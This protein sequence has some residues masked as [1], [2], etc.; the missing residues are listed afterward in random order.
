MRL[1][2]CTLLA[3]IC[4]LLCSSCF[5]PK[6]LMPGLTLPPG[7]TVS[8]TTNSNTTAGGMP[9]VPPMPGLGSIDKSITVTF[10]NS[11]GWAAVSG[12]FDAFMQSRGY[13]ESMQMA[14]QMGGGS[15][16]GQT[17]QMQQMMQGMRSYIKMGD[18]YAV[19]LM[20]NNAILGAAGGAGGM[21]PMG[22]GFTLYVMKF[23]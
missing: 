12:H 6:Y 8:T 17:A 16:P 11:G 14:S 9:G 10:D 23:K 4:M 5:G 15:I 21:N 19:S 1:I 3:L 7:S 20:D 13:T 22:G 2:A 18:K